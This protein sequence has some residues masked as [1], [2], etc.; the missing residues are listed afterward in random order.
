MQKQG[1]ETNA[2]K[3]DKKEVP[4]GA[5][6]YLGSPKG[7]AQE[8]ERAPESPRGLQRGSPLGG[9]ET[10][11]SRHHWV[12]GCA[13]LKEQVIAPDLEQESPSQ[14]QGQAY[15]QSQCQRQ[16]QDLDLDP[17]IWIWIEIND[18]ISRK[19]WWTRNAQRA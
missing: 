12:G 8:R 5:K 16:A 7:A 13:A 4:K 17:K 19:A 15:R 11:S 1:L 14:S 6:R 3:S 10:Q 18:G 9:N 2:P